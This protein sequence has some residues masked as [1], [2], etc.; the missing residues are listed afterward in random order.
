MADSASSNRLWLSLSTVVLVLY[1]FLLFFRLGYYPF[2]CDEADTALYARGVARTGDTYA[3]LDHNVYAFRNGTCL[4]D[5]RERYEPPAPFYLAA[6]FVGREGTEAFWPRFPFA[7]CGL[8]SVALVLYWLRRDAIGP[9][10]CGLM[11]LG[12]LLNVSMA[13]YFRQCRYYGLATLLSVAMA[14]CY[15]HWEG[16]R[17]T[18]I[19]FSLLG[20][21]LLAT[22][23]LAY[24][25]M[26]AAVLVDY[27]CFAR[28]ERRLAWRD[29]AIVVVPQVAV[30][31]IV[32]WIW[33]PLN[34]D[35]VD[36]PAEHAWL[37]ERLILLGRNL[38]DLN[39]CE[40]GAGLLLLAAPALY[41]VD[42][43][44]WLLRGTLTIVVYAAAVSF[45][46]PQPVAQT[47]GADIR[48]LSALIPLCIALGCLAIWTVSRR[49]WWLALPLAVI[50]FGTN[51]CNVPH[52]PASWRSTSWQWFAELGAP[53]TTA[54]QQ[55]IDWIDAHVVYGQSVWVEPDALQYPLMY[56]APQAVYAWQLTYP[57]Q[58]Q[59]Q[60]LPRINFIGDLAPDYIIE[61]GRRDEVQQII[62]MFQ[63]DR[64]VTYSQ[65]AALDVFW[66]EL[67]RPEI[68]SHGFAPISQFD[69]ATEGVYIWRRDGIIGKNP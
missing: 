57:P 16:R 20:L 34:K 52:D 39:S 45:F 53:R 63:R 14:Y 27:L 31:L 54:T 26:M 15:V 10:A 67:I 66:D 9:L 30:G 47:T 11:G 50:A 13:L 17:R 58:G 40:Y 5:L 60:S 19:V 29:W 2:W 24:A 46:S 1:A 64:R 62:G 51:L 25:G 69:P 65:V 22:H 8:L 21:L 33:N 38:R 56:H 7:V 42:R 3:V 49:K 59:F 23:Y 68:F 6:P 32:V 37:V 41:L 48:Y 44:R 43:N 28:R 12:I 55:M 18:I 61:F 35:V 36:L 4:V